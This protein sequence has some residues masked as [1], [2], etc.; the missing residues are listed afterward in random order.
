MN[1]I[2]I[3]SILLSYCFLFLYDCKKQT[4]TSSIDYICGNWISI[5]GRPRISILSTDSGY[6]AIVHHIT[7]NREKY[8]IIY[9]ILQTQYGTYIQ[10]EGRIFISYSKKD[11]TLFLSPGGTYIREEYK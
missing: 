4:D 7:V 2:I 3:T 11:S 9:P 8:P 10:A 5:Q 1:K 6:I